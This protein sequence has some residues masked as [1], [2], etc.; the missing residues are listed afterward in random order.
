MKYRVPEG[1][2]ILLMTRSGRVDWIDHMDQETAGE[3]LFIE[4][5][6]RILHEEDEIPKQI[7][8]GIPPGAWQYF[9]KEGYMVFFYQG[10]EYDAIAVKEKALE[11]IDE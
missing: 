1:S 6:D 3:D 9:F 5:I 11:K 8:G 4:K 10:N 2:E 7:H